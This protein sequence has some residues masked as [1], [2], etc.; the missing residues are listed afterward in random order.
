MIMDRI[1]VLGTSSTA[2]CRILRVHLGAPEDSQHVFCR[3]FGNGYSPGAAV[4]QIHK[5]RTTASNINSLT[6]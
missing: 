1:E 3:V 5:A 2:E 6:I 4:G